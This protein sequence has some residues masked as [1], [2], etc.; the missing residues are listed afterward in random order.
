MRHML[1]SASNFACPLC[2]A[3]ISGYE[4]GRPTS[5]NYRRYQDPERYQHRVVKVVDRVSITVV[6]RRGEADYI[7]YIKRIPSGQDE[8]EVQMAG[9]R[10]CCL[11]C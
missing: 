2:R 8:S 5:R 10:S 9:G 11:V 3:T 6:T 4:A 7:L 1:H